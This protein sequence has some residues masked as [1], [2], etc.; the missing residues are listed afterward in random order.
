MLV[1]APFPITLAPRPAKALRRVST[2]GSPYSVTVESHEIAPLTAL[3]GKAVRMERSFSA[4]LL[5]L[6]LRHN[7]EGLINK[8]EAHM[9]ASGSPAPTPHER[10]QRAQNNFADTHLLRWRI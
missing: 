2:A 6:G 5:E 10:Y 4:Q 9:T 3:Q 8:A 7:V 1:P